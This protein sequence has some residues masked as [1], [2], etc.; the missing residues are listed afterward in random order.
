MS[1]SESRARRTIAFGFP[2]LLSLSISC[3]VA[4]IPTTAPPANQ[5]TRV[6]LPVP[7]DAG[8]ARVR[9]C[10]GA[11]DPPAIEEEQL[12][13][14]ERASANAGAS[15]HPKAG[16]YSPNL[17]KW[18]ERSHAAGERQFFHNSDDAPWMPL[19]EFFERRVDED[20][21][22]EGGWVGF[23][24]V[25]HRRL[26]MNAPRPGDVH[27]R[28]WASNIA[29]QELG[30]NLDQA[31]LLGDLRKSTV[32]LALWIDEKGRAN[33]EFAYVPKGC[34]R[35]ENYLRFVQIGDTLVGLTLM[36]HDTARPEIAA[37]WLHSFFDAPLGVRRPPERRFA[38]GHST[39]F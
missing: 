21:E 10:V 27:L 22:G 34:E 26:P 39:K 14:M 32:Y 12:V 13:A 33:L 38:Y 19:V 20:A 1:S 5:T 4:T 11:S 29:K 2:C 9:G 36:I 3:G 16:S 18:F 25:E 28:A 7:V 17:P 6:A 37:P 15:K 30:E 8:A 31:N 23:A 35:M 24:L